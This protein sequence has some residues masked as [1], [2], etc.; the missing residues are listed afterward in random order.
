MTIPTQPGQDPMAAV[1]TLRQMIMGFRITQLLHVA[2]RLG[3]ADLL[4]DEPQSPTALAAATGANAQALRRLLRA[5]ASL[6][7]FAERD[8]GRYELTPLAHPLRSDAP[9]SAR[10]LALLYGDAVLWQAYGQMLYSVQT[11]LPAFDHV[12]GASLYAYLEQHP[13]EGA[14]FQGA[15]SAYSGQEM[16]AILA[17]YDFT[18]VARLVDVGGGYG[19]LLAAILQQYPTLHGVLFDLPAV[20]EQ[21]Q[22]KLGE[23]GVLERCEPVGGDFF[24]GLPAGGQIYLLKSVLH[25]WP[26]AQC[27]TILQ[28]C[29]QGLTPGGRV[30]VV[31]RV[32][33]PGN[34]PAE[35]KLFDINML[36]VLNGQ[37][38]TEAE[39]SALFAAAGLRL[40]RTVPTASP[41]SILEAEIGEAT[42]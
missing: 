24:V 26:D 22:Q 12:H 34:E 36:V 6:G 27:V 33:P 5:L 10:G 4:I 11:G 9:G 21:A 31:E 13:A 1:A 17:A 28:H 39:Y 38:R 23:A 8:D 42:A 32:I 35:A 25:N 19:G 37:E 3:L 29:R 18:G 15:M 41:L 14:V 40:I 16:V 30:L 20:V 7:I 2:A